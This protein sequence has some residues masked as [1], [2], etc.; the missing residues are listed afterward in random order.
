M[1]VFGVRLDVDLVPRWFIW[2][3]GGLRRTLGGVG[4]WASVDFS[5]VGA[6]WTHI[7]VVYLGGVGLVFV[8]LIAGWV[9]FI[10]CFVWHGGI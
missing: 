10:A 8:A 9:S 6:A 7:S 4:M 3:G 2:R 1:G 5:K